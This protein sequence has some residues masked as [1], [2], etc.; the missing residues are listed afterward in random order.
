[1]STT[2][3]IIEYSVKSIAVIGDTKNIKDELKELG[4][5]WNPNLKDKNNQ[6]MKGWIFSKKKLPEVEKLLNISDKEVIP[7]VPIEVPIEVSD[8]EVS[9]EDKEIQELKRLLVQK[10]KEIE[11]LKELN[12]KLMT[13]KFEYDPVEAPEKFTGNSIVFFEDNSIQVLENTPVGHED[14]E[15]WL[16]SYRGEKTFPEIWQEFVGEVTVVRSK[17]SN[18][19]WDIEEEEEEIIPEIPEIPKIPKVPIFVPEE[20]VSDKEVIPEIPDEIPEEVP[21]LSKMTYKELKRKATDMNIKGRSK[22]KNKSI[23]IKA[24]TQQY[25]YHHQIMAI[26]T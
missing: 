11:E 1:M 7:E 20:E 19:D 17:V 9:K 16:G 2:I 13:E 6:P 3:Q 8:E 4:G 14:I 22:L 26:F 10:D 21:D 15:S 12:E 24:I 23:L 25:K 5:R 18:E